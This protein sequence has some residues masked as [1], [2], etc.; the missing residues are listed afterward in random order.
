VRFRDVYDQE[1]RAVAVLAIPLLQVASLAT[2][3]GSGEAPEQQN[4][5]PVARNVKIHHLGR[6]QPPQGD[7]R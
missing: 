6:T 2:E 3:G 4:K 7:G 1:L 5:R